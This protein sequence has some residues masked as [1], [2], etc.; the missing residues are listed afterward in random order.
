ML[1]HA[2]IVAAYGNLASLGLSV[3]IAVV[4]ALVVLIAR[5]I[6]LFVMLRRLPSLPAI[7]QAVATLHTGERR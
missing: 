4:Y 5:T 7:P 6:E 2:V 3:A 1:P